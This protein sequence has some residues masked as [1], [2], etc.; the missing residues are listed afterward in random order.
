M[1]PHLDHQMPMAGI[2][3]HMPDP[4]NK[5]TMEQKECSNRHTEGWTKN[6]KNQDKHYQYLSKVKAGKGQIDPTMLAEA[7]N[8]LLHFQKH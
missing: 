3:D 4:L 2:Q 1:N 7:L 8:N 6:P 5:L